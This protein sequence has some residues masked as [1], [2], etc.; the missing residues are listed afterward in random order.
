MFPDGGHEQGQEGEGDDGQVIYLSYSRNEI[1]NQVNGGKGIKSR[2]SQEDKLASGEQARFSFPAAEVIDG[3]DQKL[4]PGAVGRNGN[5][6]FP[7]AAG[8]NLPSMERKLFFIWAGSRPEGRI[9]G[10]FVLPCPGSDT[11]RDFLKPFS[12]GVFSSGKLFSYCL[13][14]SRPR[15]EQFPASSGNVLPCV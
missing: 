8:V 1:R 13:M 12:V 2:Q 4:L 7:G 5:L 11:G 9:T 14:H 3:P 15:P 6:V 10:P